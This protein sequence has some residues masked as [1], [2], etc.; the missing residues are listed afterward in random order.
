MRVRYGLADPF[1]WL[2]YER[3]YRDEIALARRGEAE[4]STRTALL[5]TLL[6]GLTF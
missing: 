6:T 5:V 2:Q 4:R 3:G 1:L